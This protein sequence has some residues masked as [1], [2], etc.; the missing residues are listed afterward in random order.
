MY[1]G[2]RP[3]ASVECNDPVVEHHSVIWDWLQS[4]V[5]EYLNDVRT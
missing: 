2:K 5:M 4:S 3:V 1:V